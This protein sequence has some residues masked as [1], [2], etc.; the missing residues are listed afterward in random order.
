MFKS[1]N[2]VTRHVGST[3]GTVSAWVRIA[4]LVNMDCQVSSLAYV[5]VTVLR[6]RRYVHV[7]LQ[8]VVLI[9]LLIFLFGDVDVTVSTYMQN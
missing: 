7:F 2:V 9:D 4:G 6:P 8:K 1:V 3:G 5:D